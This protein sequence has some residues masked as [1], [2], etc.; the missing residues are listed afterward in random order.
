[1]LPIF[2]AF[3]AIQVNF[4]PTSNPAENYLEVLKTV[5]F[6]KD[7][8]NSNVPIASKINHSSLY[9]Y[10]VLKNDIF[11]AW[12]DT[13]WDFNGISNEPKKGQI[14]CGYFVSTTLKHVGFNLN[15]Y[16]LAQQ[17]ASVIVNSICEKSNVKTYGNPDSL[18]TYLAKKPNSLY[19]V[20]LDNHVGFLLVENKEVYFVHSDYFNRKVVRELAKTST[21]FSY[22][23]LFVLGEISNN[24]SLMLKWLNQTKI[25]G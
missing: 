12:Y 25:Y 2:I 8:I 22:S 15:R 7:S 16:K 3:L 6:K 5:E 13:P 21:A 1:M 9:L 24:K 4:T 11:P 18:I 19:C 14:A 10:Q 23:K 17:A 20:G